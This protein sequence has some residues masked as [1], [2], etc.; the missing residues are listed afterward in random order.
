MLA[1]KFPTIDTSSERQYLELKK[2][3]N[4]MQLN[5]QSF[6]CVSRYLW[7]I[8]LWYQQHATL[9]PHYHRDIRAYFYAF[10]AGDLLNTTLSDFFLWGYLKDALY[11]TKPATLLELG[12][13]IAGCFA[14]VPEANLMAVC[15]V[16]CSPKSTVP[17]S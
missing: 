14:V 2:R 10:P 11:S 6:E 1:S 13:E 17:Q 16:N 5:L 15:Q 8:V 9:P 7:G 12:Q 4:R 3:S